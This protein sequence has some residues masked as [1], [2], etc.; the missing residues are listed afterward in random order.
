[1]PTIDDNY[2][3]FLW[4]HL[5]ALDSVEFYSTNVPSNASTAQPTTR[6]SKKKLKKSQAD[7]DS[8]FDMD[9]VS[10]QVELN[11][12]VW[13]LINDTNMFSLYIDLFHPYIDKNWLYTNR[14]KQY[15]LSAID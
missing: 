4:A 7:S 2:K 10:E 5:R 12:E 3:A 15:Q 11:K 14:C 8:D 9:H 6:E 13:L 1:M